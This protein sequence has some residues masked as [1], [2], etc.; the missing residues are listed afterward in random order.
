[1][2]KI[3]YKFLD[4]YAGKGLQR[5][6]SA[7][8]YDPFTFQ[9]KVSVMFSSDG[10]ILIL[11]LVMNDSG[12]VIRANTLLIDIIKGFIPV[13]DADCHLY[14][15]SWFCDRNNIKK[16]DLISNYIKENEKLLSPAY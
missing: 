12:V 7:L 4:N 8:L 9:P 10:G 6:K 5:D 3:V 15:V 1:M 14:I 16:E 13:N 2:K 11:R